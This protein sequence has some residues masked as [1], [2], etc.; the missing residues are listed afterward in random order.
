[1]IQKSAGGGDN[2][3]NVSV[4]AAQSIKDGQTGSFTVTASGGTVSS[5][6]WSFTAPS[7]AGNGPNVSF[8]AA[9]S[10]QTNTD[11]HWFA[12]P[13]VACPTTSNIPAYYDAIYAIT[14]KVTFSTGDSI[15]KSTNL[16]VN[17]YWNPAGY[18]DPNQTDISGGPTIGP[19]GSGTWH[20]VS[21]GTL[22]RMVPTQATIYVI[23][24]SQFYNKTV[25]HEQVH[26]N[27]WI[28]G[29]GHLYGDLYIPTDF[30]NQIKDLTGTSDTD[31]INKMIQVKTT[32]IN[33]QGALAS[34]RHNQDEQQAY[35][36]SDPLAPQYAYQNC[37]K[38]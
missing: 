23:P 19:D 37:G 15:T 27:N 36:V 25:Q 13:N 26:V 30:Y 18:T 7:G 10:A 38:Y 9:T 2:V 32:Y 4:S 6:N 16:T 8:T 21:M 22:A 31:L 17:S 34:G 11:G 3:R 24:T 28:L 12:L 1:M 20:V 14:A 33:S 29:A 5:Y 35:A